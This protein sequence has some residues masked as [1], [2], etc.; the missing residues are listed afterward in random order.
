MQRSKTL[1]YWL[2]IGSVIVPLVYVVQSL[3]PLSFPKASLMQTIISVAA[4]LAAWV[5]AK[6]AST[7]PRWSLLLGFILL[8]FAVQVLAALFGID[9]HQ[10]WWSE[11][12][13]A[14]GLFFQLHILLLVL[15]VGSGLLTLA[16]VR[17]VVIASCAV[18]VVVSVIGI[19]QYFKPDIIPNVSA[20]RI[21]STLGNPVFLASYLVLHIFLVPFLWSWF[22]TSKSRVLLGLGASVMLVALLLTHGRGSY[23]GLLIGGFVFFVLLV[24]EKKPQAMRWVYGAMIAAL[25]LLAGLWAARDSDF[26]RHSPFLHAVTATSTLFSRS[27]N[28]SIAWHG[29]LD[30]PILGWGPETYRSVLDVFFDSRLTNISFLE[31]F[32]D[33]PHNAYL[34][35]LV[36]SGGV[37]LF[38][39]GAVVVLLF[40]WISRLKR[41]GVISAYEY[42]GVCSLLVAHG[43]QNFFL[44][45]TIA[46]Y[47]TLGLI[48]GYI[49]AL[50]RS[51]LAASRVVSTARRRAMQLSAIVASGVVVL[52][53]Y[54]LTL[55]PFISSVVTNRGLQYTYSDDWLQARERLMRALTI[56]TPYAFERWRWSSA[57]AA[58]VVYAKTPHQT[59]QELPPG[60]RLV[61]RN[62]RETFA[63]EGERLLAKGPR[64][65]L[66]VS[67][68][69][70]YYYQLAVATKD[71]RY[72]R[73]AEE[74]FR[75]ATTLS[76]RREEGYL[77]LAQTAL[78]RKDY[79]AAEQ[80]TASVLQRNPESN[81]VRWYHAFALLQIEGRQRE[82]LQEAARAIEQGFAFENEAQ[83]NVLAQYY[84]EQKDYEGLVQLYEIGTQFFPRSAELYSHLA[85]AYAAVGRYSDARSAVLHSVN[86]DPS[87]AKDAE[88]F[89]KQ[90][91]K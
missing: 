57:A 39:Y 30:R 2:C 49:L 13:R 89:L 34:E 37:G 8:F 58:E 33:K 6:D 3:F 81:L 16:R 78:Y 72:V 43:V 12:V 71:D 53:W 19:I 77:L 45:E 25:L 36:G 56:D 69:G 60:L 4:I 23:L 10:S 29:F 42:A 63:Q 87:F 74:L 21:G 50:S 80:I 54:Q 75:E 65:F 82:G 59:E 27:I 44:F 15:I 64:T 84:G 85:A 62:D 1:L 41:A 70:K 20:V 47:G 32:V 18:A 31:T 38:V 46:T 9:S 83:L 28:W 55:L 11:M 51:T 40:V 52:V 48:V 76:P 61:W 14:T 66:M 79:V 17:R 73:R 24:R 7:R 90:L 86:L 5:W 26:V 91:P 68:L 67:F 35:I 88:A 22:T